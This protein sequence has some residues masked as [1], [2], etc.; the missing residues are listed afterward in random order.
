MDQQN[1]MLSF[2]SSLFLS[3]TRSYT[4]TC[5]CPLC[6]APEIALAGPVRPWDGRY[7]QCLGPLAGS[8][9]SGQT[10]IAQSPQSPHEHLQRAKQIQ[11]S[12]QAS[13]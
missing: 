9:T 2:S 3:D 7:D 4:C 13:W 1:L 5:T 6:Q 12:L 10:A 8:A 11:K